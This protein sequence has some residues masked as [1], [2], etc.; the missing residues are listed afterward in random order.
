MDD[1]ARD[2]VSFLA[3][4]Y[5]IH[6]ELDKYESHLWIMGE[7]Y[8]GKYVPAIAT[9]GLLKHGLANRYRFKGVAIGNGYT[10]PL[11]MATTVA[12]SYYALGLIDGNQRD[13]ANARINT[14]VDLAKA[15]KWGMAADC[16]A[17]FMNYITR[18]AGNANKLDVRVFEPYNFTYIETFMNGPVGRKQ[19]RIP[20]SVSPRYCVSGCHDVATNLHDDKMKGYAHLLPP[21]LEAGHKVL[22]YTG[23]MDLRDGVAATEAWLNHSSF[24]QLWP[25]AQEFFSAERQT[26][27]IDMDCDHKNNGVAGFVK[28]HANLTQAVVVGAGHM[29]PRD[30]PVRAQEMISSFVHGTPPFHSK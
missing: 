21:I 2:F 23:Q 17:G 11:P 13:H 12:N 4:F 29:V 8:A 7:S 30:Q 6:P 16:R 1:V 5:K 20:D 26:W 19:F 3:G 27:S 28:T 25:F 15:S 14:C 18:S 24:A 10:E 22:L 9:L